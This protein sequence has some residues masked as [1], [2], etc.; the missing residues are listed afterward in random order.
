MEFYLLVSKDGWLENPRTEW[1]FLMNITYKWS[2]FHYHV[3]LPDG[4]LRSFP[5]APWCW[6]IYLYFGDIWGMLTHISIH[7]GKFSNDLTVLI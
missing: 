7:L 6:Y 4:K 2:I 5:Y 1:R 3:E